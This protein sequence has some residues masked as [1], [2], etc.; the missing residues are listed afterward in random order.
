MAPLGIV[1]PTLTHPSAHSL[2]HSPQTNFSRKSIRCGGWTD[3]DAGVSKLPPSG[4][5]ARS[6][7][8]LPKV[9]VRFLSNNE[10]DG[11]GRTLTFL[12]KGSCA[13]P[14]EGKDEDLVRTYIHAVDIQGMQPAQ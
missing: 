10:P 9:I 11:F 5:T 4:V 6:L 3:A 7:R 8:D 2:T 12:T 1:G 14:I 13:S